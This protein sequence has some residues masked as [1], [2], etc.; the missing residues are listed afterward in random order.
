MTNTASRKSNDTRAV[1]VNVSCII[2]TVE[3]LITEMWSQRQS[4]REILQTLWGSVILACQAMKH[5]QA[6][7]YSPVL[8]VTT[9]PHSLGCIPKV[10]EMWQ[11]L[12]GG[13]REYL[14]DWF[15]GQKWWCFSGTSSLVSWSAWKPSRL[16]AFQW[17]VILILQHLRLW[18]VFPLLP[19]SCQYFNGKENKTQ[20][21]SAEGSTMCFSQVPILTASS[22]IAWVSAY[23]AK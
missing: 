15:P 8:G 2:A 16:A 10:D 23:D 6:G 20:L 22:I 21:P 9:F 12:L 14:W 5:T 1:I 18:F 11:V 13:E 17:P 4:S 7:K 19:L 3:P